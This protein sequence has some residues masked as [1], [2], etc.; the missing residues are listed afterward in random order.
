[1]TSIIGTPAD[2]R[3]EEVSGRTFDEEHA[4]L[5]AA[6]E[7]H[8]WGQ[9]TLGPVLLRHDDVRALLRCPDVE[10][11]GV[12]LMEVNGVT[13]GPLHEWWS[14]IMFANEGEKHHRMRSVARGWLTPK[15]VAD[16]AEREVAAARGGLP[17]RS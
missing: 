1:M 13:S 9:G 2:L 4:L 7:Q 5:A 17:P 16:L 8:P 15:R 10:Q 3:E 6:R 14:Q 11:M 12:A